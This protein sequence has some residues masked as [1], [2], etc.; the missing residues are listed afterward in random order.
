MGIGATIASIAT[1]LRRLVKRDTDAEDPDFRSE[2]SRLPR[3]KRPLHI[4]VLSLLGLL[5]LYAVLLSYAAWG[6]EAPRSSGGVVTM[7]LACAAIG[8][9]L[10]FIFAIP[11]RVEVAI[12]KPTEEPAAG[13]EPQMKSGVADSSYRPNTSLEEISDWLTKIIVGL[14]LVEARA[15]GS[16][17][18]TQ[19]AAMAPIIFGTGASPILGSAALVAASTIAFLASFL[20]FR[21]YLAEEFTRSDQDTARLAQ[22]GFDNAR[23]KGRIQLVG[24]R[25]AL[26]AIAQ[27]A[28]VPLGSP[29]PPAPPA[30][31]PSGR[32][33]PPPAPAAPPPPA[34]FTPA[35]ASAVD[36]LQTAIE[37]KL[38]QMRDHPLDP[39]DPAKGAFGGVASVATP[40]TRS[41]TAIVEA[42]PGDTNWFKISLILA[43]GEPKLTGEVAFFYH[44]TFQVPY[45]RI[46]VSDG[47]AKVRLYA[48]GAFTVGALADDGATELELDLASLESAPRAFREA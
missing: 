26:R 44:P 33:G 45:E 31:P 18:E 37:A 19:G 28:V 29:P 7:L 10:G 11:K 8:G 38:A 23:G 27:S 2:E 5:A 25:R 22:S 12:I 32:R 21:L 43:S 4:V 24:P 36:S 15:I 17:V 41:L 42:N 3:R 16:F 9:L 1:R 6:Q 13:N 48:Y 14:G 34:S 40:G 39:S 20:Y 47:Q 30:P 46:R 35:P